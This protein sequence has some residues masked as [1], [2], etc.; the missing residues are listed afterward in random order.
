MGS[1]SEIHIFIGL[2]AIFFFFLFYHRSSG[3]QAVTEIQEEKNEK[4]KTAKI[5]RQI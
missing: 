5:T 2:H 3:E 4:C 1:Q